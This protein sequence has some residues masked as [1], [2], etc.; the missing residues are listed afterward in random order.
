[1]D[2]HG[3]DPM[4]SH[5]H[6]DWRFPTDNLD[7]VIVRGPGHE[8]ASEII[9]DI[10]AGSVHTERLDPQQPAVPIDRR[11]DMTD[12][13]GRACRYGS[14]TRLMAVAHWGKHECAE[15]ES[16]RDAAQLQIEHGVPDCPVSCTDR[17]SG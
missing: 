7:E 6:A 10:A 4:L 3:Y 2:L 8:K 13:P 15:S 17:D 12:A 1:M 5:W 11:C 16:W 9:A 14:R